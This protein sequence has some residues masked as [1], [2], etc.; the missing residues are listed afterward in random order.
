MRVERKND[1]ITAH[2]SHAIAYF[3]SIPLSHSSSFSFSFFLFSSSPPLS[4]SAH[5][6]LYWRSQ[7][8]ASMIERAPLQ[9][10]ALISDDRSRIKVS[11]REVGLGIMFGSSL[12]HHLLRMQRVVS[13]PS[14]DQMPGLYRKLAHSTHACAEAVTIMALA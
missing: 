5:P 7:L 4:L 13:I 12:V 3:P 1:T 2:L 10:L 6:P 14:V 8:L 9:G 11:S